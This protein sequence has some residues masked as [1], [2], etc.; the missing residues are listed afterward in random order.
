MQSIT[1]T[2]YE[3]DPVPRGRTFFRALLECF[4][5]NIA[6]LV[7][8]EDRNAMAHGLELCAPFMDHE[9]VEAAFG[10]PYHRFMEGG[11][12]K[13][14]LR[15]AVHR[16]LAPEVSQYPCKLATPGSD[17]Y[18]AFEVLRPQFLDMFSS[19]SFY[20]SGLWSHRCEE[21]YAFDQPKRPEQV[22][23]FACT[24][25]KN[26]TNTSRQ[27][28]RSRREPVPIIF[29]FNSLNFHEMGHRELW[30][31]LMGKSRG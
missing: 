27:P 18:V 6:L 3:F 8:L 1:T 26:G 9:L 31:R 20:A 13:A 4:R 16:L 22:F 5:K 23:G 19:A 28:D 24:W 29:S 30:S 11:R 25:H 12:N 10:L 17:S 15:K 7:R 2:D 21:L 14:A